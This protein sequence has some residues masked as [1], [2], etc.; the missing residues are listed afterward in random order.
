MKLNLSSDFTKNMISK[1]LSSVIRNKLGYNVDVRLNGLDV[2]I[3]DGNARITVNAQA[4]VAKSE[5]N[6]IV[7]NI[8]GF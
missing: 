6:K 3:V 5:L 8:T 4:D 2:Q 7:Q 1:V